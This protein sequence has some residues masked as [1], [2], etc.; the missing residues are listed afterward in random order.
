MPQPAANQATAEALIRVYEDAHDSLVAAWQAAATDERRARQ[1][2]RLRELLDTHE[3]TM[4]ALTD[5]SR[6]W[7]STSVPILHAA[8]AGQAA[9]VVGSSFT[10]TQAHLAAVEAFAARTWDDVA[11]NLQ[12]ITA[13]TR[14][15]IRQEIASATRTVLLESRT[16]VQA[17]RDVAREAAKRGL[18]SVTY[19]NGARHTMRDYAD[20]AVRTTTAEAYNRGST[21]QTIADGYEWIE[22]FDGDDCGITSH[23][24]PDK[25]NGQIVPIGDVVYLSHPRCRRAILPALP[26]RS[27]ADGVALGEALPPE[28]APISARQP[29]QPRT[30]R[31][32]RGA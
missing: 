26:G 7:W 28:P 3:A 8:G 4:A 12:A 31:Q 15:L 19:A 10:W 16:A 30:A 14:R 23:E 2:R 22:Y 21:T 25:A 13:E 24:D 1:T 27:L 11:A 29:R 18:W 9:A 6:T 20:M 5:T 17:G 32:P